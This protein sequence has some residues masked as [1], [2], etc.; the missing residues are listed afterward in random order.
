M[1]VSETRSLPQR[2]Q[3]R[4]YGRSAPKGRLGSLAFL[5]CMDI[6]HKDPRFVG[7]HR[8]TVMQARFD[9]NGLVP[10]HEPKVVMEFVLVRPLGTCF[11]HF[12]DYSTSGDVL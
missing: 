3:R 9:E 12:I 1:V 6:Y 5:A 11:A 8:K 7:H 10:N 2:R 4:G